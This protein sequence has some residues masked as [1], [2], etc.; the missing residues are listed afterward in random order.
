MKK[1][2]IPERIRR[3]AVRLEPIFSNDSGSKWIIASPKRAPAA[4]LT[5]K[6]TVFL[7]LSLPMDREKIPI[8]EVKLIIATLTKV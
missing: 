4:K 3:D 1:N 5:K 6:T 7:S 8:S 2:I